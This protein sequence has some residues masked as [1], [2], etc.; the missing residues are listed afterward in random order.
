MKDKILADIQALAESLDVPVTRDLYRAQGNFVDKEVCAV[1]GTFQELR[2][3]AG[4]L[5][6]REQQ[7][8]ANNLAQHVSMDTR[9]VFTAEK[10]KWAGTYKK[11][12]DTRW[13]TYMT[14][15]DMHDIECDSFWRHVFIDT[16]KRIQPNIITINGDAIDLPEF[17]KYTVDPREWDV[18]G[19]IKWLHDFL[20][21]LR[22]ACPNTQIDFIEGNHEHRLLKHLCEA[23]PA[24]MSILGDLHGWTVSGILGLDKYEVNYIAP[25]DLRP[26]KKYEIN[27][28]LGRNFKIYNGFLVKCHFPDAQRWNMPGL[29]GHH[30]KHVCKTFYCP[31]RGTFEWHQTGGGHVRKA[32]YCNGEQWSNGFS[33]EHVDTKKQLV[34]FEYIDTTA[35]FC[36]VGG[37]F[38]S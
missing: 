14:C 36:V 17:S 1:F 15:S 4:L 3:Q 33:I 20:S 19:R 28:E 13:Q 11:P 23:S 21:D 8:L 37:K 12:S 31:V 9:R 24:M 32:S 25:A 27:S 38:Y 35:Q 30:H 10:R 22:D 34:Q 6:T 2:R 26:N 29:N 18:V 7:K 16:A 5:P